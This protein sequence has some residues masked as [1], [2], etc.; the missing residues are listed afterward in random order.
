M[1]CK[2]CTRPIVGPLLQGH[3]Y[4]HLFGPENHPAEPI[5]DRPKWLETVEDFERRHPQRDPQ[6]GG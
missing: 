6:T 2:H 4:Y 3:Y 1:N 5:D